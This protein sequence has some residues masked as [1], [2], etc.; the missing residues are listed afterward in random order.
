MKKFFSLFVIAGL[1]VVGLVVFYLNHHSEMKAKEFKEKLASTR[2][3][4]AEKSAGLRS[5]GT[6]NEYVRDQNELLKA[7]KADLEKLA[8]LDE[9]VLDVDHEKK[10]FA[11]ADEKKPP[12][13]E[14]KK[15]RDEYFTLAKTA[16]EN[17]LSGAYRPV[18]TAFNNGARLDITSLK[19]VTTPDGE[20]ALRAD[21]IAWGFPTEV[22]YG[23]INMRVWVSKE[24]KV[25][26]KVEKIDEIKYKFDAAGA[27]PTIAIS[28]PER[29][30]QSFPPGGTI[31]YY[32]LQLMPRE[33]EKLDLSF[34]YKMTTDAGRVVQVDVAF[35]KLPVTEPIMMSPGAK[36]EAQEKEATD[37][38]RQGRP[39]DDGKSAKK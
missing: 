19:R 3:K 32:Y 8:K 25:K 36:L 16:Y 35:D 9:S 18:L 11:E 12:S 23:D 30:V 4:Y 15:L 2:Q 31:G 37:A 17:L 1:A 34:H 5:S 13:A 7:Y 20:E 22:A 33:S 21:F 38:E 26:G 14:Q 29:W 24:Q 27:H 6:P 10:K 39:E 28:N